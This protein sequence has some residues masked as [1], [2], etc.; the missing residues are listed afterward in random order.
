[1]D[2][3]LKELEDLIL[4]GRKPTSNIIKALQRILSSGELTKTEERKLRALQRQAQRSVD[5]KKSVSLPTLEFSITRNKNNPGKKLSETKAMAEART[6]LKDKPR[7]KLA[8]FESKPSTYKI[9]KG[10]TLSGIAKKLGSTVSELMSA[11][12]NSIKDKNKIRA[13]QTINIRGS[14][15]ASKR[16]ALDAPAKTL[17]EALRR[18]KSTYGTGKNKKAAVTKEQLKK[19]GLSLREYLNKMN[20]KKK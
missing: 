8:S 12:K 14:S 20:K 17:S 18:G 11:N 16:E 9:K 10:D 15:I 7:R 1:M 3:R 13:G 6:K 5:N 19:S 4:S 2:S